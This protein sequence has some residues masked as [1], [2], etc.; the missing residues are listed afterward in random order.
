MSAKRFPPPCRSSRRF[1]TPCSRAHPATY[2]QVIG[3]PVLMTIAS[4]LDMRE[5]RLVPRRLHTKEVPAF[6]L[7]SFFLFG[8]QGFNGTRLPSACTLTHEAPS[9]KST[10]P[11][12]AQFSA[13]TSPTLPPRKLQPSSCSRHKMVSVCSNAY[14]HYVAHCGMQRLLPAAHPHHV[15]P[16]LCIVWTRT[17]AFC[18]SA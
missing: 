17:A 18:E 14:M 15:L 2:A 9:S 8:N 3:F 10:S 11:L 12:L 7:M 4:I 1:L 13:F 6:L 5:I 16:A